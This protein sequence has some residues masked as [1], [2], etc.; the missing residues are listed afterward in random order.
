MTTYKRETVCVC[1]SFVLPF[2]IKFQ[3]GGLAFHF[4]RF[5][6]ATH[7]SHIWDAFA[8]YRVLLF[9]FNIFRSEVVVRF[10]YITDI[11]NNHCLKTILILTFLLDPK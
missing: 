5:S 4:H 2:N 3:K 11:I 1:I 9:L 6:R 7:L 10:A 8:I